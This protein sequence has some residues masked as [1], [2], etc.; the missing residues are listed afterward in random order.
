MYGCRKHLR[1]VRD[2]I[3]KQKTNILDV[4]EVDLKYYTSN[5]LADWIGIDYRVLRIVT[6]RTTGKSIEKIQSSRKF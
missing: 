1:L 4:S 6:I 5:V 3:N 2:F